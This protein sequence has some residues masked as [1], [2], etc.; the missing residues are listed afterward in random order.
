MTKVKLIFPCRVDWDTMQPHE[1][2]KFC[3]ECKKAVRDYVN[4]EPDLEGAKPF[5][6]RFRSDQIE[7]QTSTAHILNYQT[8]S[9]SLLTLLG[10]TGADVN[11]QILP[12]DSTE[13]KHNF[14]F[15][16]LKFPLRLEGS[17]RNKENN[18]TISNALIS[19]KQTGQEVYQTK[20][21]SSGKFSFVLLD[22]DI[23]DSVFDL[24]VSY[25]DTLYPQKA[26]TLLQIPF[27]PNTIHH[28][29]AFALDLMVKPD[30]PVCVPNLPINAQNYTVVGVIPN[31]FH[32][33][34][35]IGGTA[36]IY[37]QIINSPVVTLGYSITPPVEEKK[38][39]PKQPLPQTN[40]AK[41]FDEAKPGPLLVKS[42]SSIGAYLI[43][44]LVAVFVGF[45]L[46]FKKFKR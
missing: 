45:F 17:I 15:S 6:G 19:L 10:A 9:L 14:Q 42:K 41:H 40:E 4:S 26:D 23:K 22:K 33:P 24:Y 20:S 18:Q 11:A 7:Y 13:V 36:I 34:V 25:A 27:L 43:G 44:A 3:Q 31:S 16:K 30:L 2:G 46:W 5:C 38:S 29:A 1:T 12:S 35:S 32:E 8:I 28:N 21:D 37:P 39:T